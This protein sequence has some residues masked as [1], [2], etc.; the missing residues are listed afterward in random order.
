MEGWVI[1][2][3]R[4]I[5][6]VYVKIPKVIRIPTDQEFAA[7][8]GEHCHILWKG[9]PAGWRCPGCD[10]TK[11][12]IM[13][14]TRRQRHG[15]P[16]FMGWMAGLHQHHDHAEDPPFSKTGRFKKE[17]ICDQCNS[18]DGLAKLKLGLPESFSFSPLEIRQFIATAPHGRHKIDLD[19]ARG[20]YARLNPDSAPS[21]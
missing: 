8:N 9:L 15:Q 6:E 21:P 7:Y 20:I 3:D 13:R 17:T 4:Q 5:D 14:W 19:K 12:E 16:A 11:L 10:R 18:V 1:F 2:L